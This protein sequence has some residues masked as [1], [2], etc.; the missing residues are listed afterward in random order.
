M[1]LIMLVLGLCVRVGRWGTHESLK[2]TLAFSMFLKVSLQLSGIRA[3]VG[4][5]VVLQV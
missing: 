2:K 1:Y 5:W 4:R 3:G